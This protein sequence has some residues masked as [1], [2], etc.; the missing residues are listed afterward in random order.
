MHEELIFPQRSGLELQDSN[1][2]SQT[3]KNGDSVEAY[4]RES[5]VCHQ[6]I[7]EADFDRIC[8]GDWQ[9]RRRGDGVRRDRFEVCSLLVQSRSQGTKSASRFP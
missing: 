1:L 7:R 6:H 3:S 2:G 4:K 9:G 8:R 5:H